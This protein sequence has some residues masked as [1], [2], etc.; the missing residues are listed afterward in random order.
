MKF[1]GILVVFAAT[2][3][4][5]QVACAAGLEGTWSGTWTKAGDPL[6]VAVTFTKA[7]EKY[8]GAFDADALQ[9]SGIPFN[10]VTLAGT[11]VHLMLRGDA[12][13]TLFDGALDGD[14]LSGTLVE[15]QV[16][17]TFHLART[18]TPPALT[19]RVITFMNGGVKLAGELL[20]PTT[21]GRHPA[22]LFL[23]GSGAEGRW[24]SRYLAQK[25]ARA[26]FVALIYDKRGVGQSSGDWRQ[27]GF[28]ELADDGV[29]GIRFLAK[30][31]EVYPS[32]IGIYG[33]SQGGTIAPLVAERAGNLAFVI[34]SAAS[35][36]DP[37]ECEI[38]S[39]DN[40]IGLAD[41]SAAERTD[42]E[43]FVREVVDVA[44]RGKDR[45]ALDAMASAYRERAWYFNLPPLD[46]SYWRVSRRV[47][48]YHPLDHWQHVQARVLLVFGDHD[49]RV[50]PKRSADAITKTLKQI[51]NKK[52]TV[53]VF[54]NAAHTFHIVPQT[55]PGGWAKRV[56]GYA[57]T[58]IAWAKAR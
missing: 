48:L 16:K 35:G 33:H 42:A 34:A 5:A 50:P 2:V 32:R 27:V 14:T 41:L 7:G 17:G 55:P 57:D 49:E 56:S 52:V 43:R 38:Y 9:V 37:A 30:Q 40:S 15:N 12:T 28:E 20:L 47:A 21:S 1:I 3:V 46:D 8:A 4:T 6:G 13:T 36:I 29:A 53:K 39:I 18:P 10:E 45:S 51:G 22:I 11:T 23:H 54:P 24:A 26:G 19:K 44:Y 25:F 31:P 58:L